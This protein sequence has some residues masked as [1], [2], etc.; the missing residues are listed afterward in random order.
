MRKTRNTSSR[1]YISTLLMLLPFIS[2]VGL[3]FSYQPLISFGVISGANAELSV[4]QLF[5]G[6]Y[7]LSSI[8]AILA[9]W[10]TLLKNPA[11]ILFI[12]FSG[13]ST[14]S[15][16]WTDNIGRGILISGLSWAI[17]FLWFAISA[18]RSSI[19][20][21]RHHFKLLVLYSSI[22]MSLFCL[23]QFFA[24][25]I[26]V[27][28]SLT[29]L[30]LAYSSDVFGFVRPTGFALEPQFL[31]SLLIGP[32]ILA[33]YLELIGK[34]TALS[35]T[36]L[37]A[38]LTVFVLTISRGAFVGLGVGMLILFVASWKRAQI[39]NYIKLI[40]LCLLGAAIGL[41][42]IFVGSELKQSDS[43]SGQKALVMATN[44]V[45]LGFFN[46]PD[47]D[48]PN[49]PPVAAEQSTPNTV[50]ESTEAIVTP[51]VAPTGYAVE[52]TNS[53]LVMWQNA[54]TIWLSSPST[55]LFGIGVGSFGAT[56][57]GINDIYSISSIVNNQYLEVLVETGIVGFALF[58]AAIIFIIYKGIIAR[59][60]ALISII[61][62][63]LVQWNFFSGSVNVLHVWVILAVAVFVCSE[64]RFSSL[65]TK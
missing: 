55:L 29:L 23:F 49:T 14:V 8:S 30:P 25:A 28:R 31:A 43:V 53:R 61:I 4:A 19:W 41:G 27:P 22:A 18:N 24:D 32:I 44:Q 5:I 36:S 11:M 9:N 60:T 54:I 38:A 3:Y 21:H 10:R 47:P 26:G 56:L 63:L 15:L 37:L 34:A 51:P 52:S 59:Q 45:T 17:L 1:S 42:A 13:V 33:S 62:A 58:A 65:S 20:K 16:L 2:L 48:V 57:N 64:K 12:L 40:S 39:T 35:R 6:L 50:T 46:I 7:I